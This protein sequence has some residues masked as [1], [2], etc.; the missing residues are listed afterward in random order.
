CIESTTKPLYKKSAN[1]H[2][3]CDR[4]QA[5][6]AVSRRALIVPTKTRGRRKENVNITYYRTP[7]LKE[8]LLRHPKARIGAN[9]RYR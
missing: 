5:A 6:S 8:E 1:P 4:G 7:D 3:A 9:F 2:L